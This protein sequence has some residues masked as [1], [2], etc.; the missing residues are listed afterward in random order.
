MHESH[1]SLF[2]AIS[3]FLLPDMF[4]ETAHFSFN[5][6]YLPLHARLVQNSED[7]SLGSLSDSSFYMLIVKGQGA[8]RRLVDAVA[9]GGNA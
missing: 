9:K 4:S 7:A 5:M 6:S 2:E 1:H 3:I 8:K